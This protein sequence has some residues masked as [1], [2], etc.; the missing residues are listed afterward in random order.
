MEHKINTISLS[1]ILLEALRTRNGNS[2]IVKIDENNI[3]ETIN[4]SSS[5]RF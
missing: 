3:H 4:W 2:S 5:M 1:N